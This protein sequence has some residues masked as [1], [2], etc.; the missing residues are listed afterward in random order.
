MNFLFYRPEYKTS[1]GKW[2]VKK[3]QQNASGNEIRPM[4]KRLQILT[5]DG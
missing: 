2:Q 3:V 5:V 4:T 1:F